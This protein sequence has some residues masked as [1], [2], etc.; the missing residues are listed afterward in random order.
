MA[1]V[2]DVD[3]SILF[4][5]RLGFRLDSAHSSPQG[6]R[7][8]ALMR[9]GPAAI[10][11]SLASGPVR[12]GEQAVL[13]YAY[14]PDAAGLREHLIGAGV[15]DAREYSGGA[16]EPVPSGR[17]WALARPFY[18]PEGEIRVE[19]PDGYTLLIGQLG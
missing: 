6:V 14:C 3:R 17:V 16:A 7:V 5:D 11:F 10:M 8:W 1:H 2:A 12:A 4:Y 13:F 15:T 19:D 9:S 18:M